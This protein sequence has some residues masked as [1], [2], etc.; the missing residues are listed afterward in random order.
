MRADLSQERTTDLYLHFLPSL[1]FLSA[2]NDE[3]KEKA[4]R[5]KEGGEQPYTQRNLRKGR[6][7][8]HYWERKK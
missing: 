2:H 4:R 6:R 3:D 1:S 7:A 8:R 5:G